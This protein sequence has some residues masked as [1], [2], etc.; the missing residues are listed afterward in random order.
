MERPRCHDQTRLCADTQRRRRAVTGRGVPFPPC[1]GRWTRR[2]ARPDEGSARK[3]LTARPHPALRATFPRKWGSN[4]SPLQLPIPRPRLGQHWLPQ[5][6]LCRFSA[7]WLLRRAS[8]RGRWRTISTAARCGSASPGCRGRARR[9]SSPRW[10]TTSST[11]AGCRCCAPRPKGAIARVHLEPQPDDA[12]PRFAY[13][14]HLA[15]ISRPSARWPKST[16]RIVAAAADDRVRARRRLGRRQAAEP[17]PRHRRLS[18]RM[19]ARPAAARQDL[20]RMVAR[21]D[22]RSARRRRARRSPAAG[23]A[24]SPAST[25]TR[26]PTRRR[27]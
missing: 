18:R 22:R 19:A 11:A 10:S 23:T 16:R 25:P 24:S 2:K 17:Q 27:R 21:D 6:L 13:E 7:I 5:A 1:G 3:R 20:R 8:S 12:V 26:R 15:A 9:C 4:C 14:E